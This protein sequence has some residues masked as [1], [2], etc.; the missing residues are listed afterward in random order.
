MRGTILESR[1]K[2]DL[3]NVD[4]ELGPDDLVGAET[5]GR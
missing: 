2:V 1:C 4:A 5:N 3:K